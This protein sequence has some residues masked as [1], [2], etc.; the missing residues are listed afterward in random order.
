MLVTESHHSTDSAPTHSLV[1]FIIGITGHRDPLHLQT[2]N[3]T[4]LEIKQ[5]IK[6]CIVYWRKKLGDKTPIW[7]MSGMAEGCDLLALEALDELRESGITGDDNFAVFPCLP[8]PSAEYEKDFAESPEEYQ[9]GLAGFNRYLNE[10]RKNMIVVSEKFQVT[11]SNPLLVEGDDQQQ[12]NYQYLNVGLF[13]AKYS[14]VLIALWDGNESK[15]VGGTADIVRYKCG[16]G[17]DWCNDKIA[18][19]LRPH[20]EFDGQ[21]GGVVQHI[22]IVRRQSSSD[23]PLLS[24]LVQL[25]HKDYADT[26]FPLYVSHCLNRKINPIQTFLS[27]EFALLNQQ[28]IRFNTFAQSNHIDNSAAKITGIENGLKDTAGLFYQADASAVVH[29]KSYR[30][31]LGSFIRIA[32]YGLITY[33]VMSI[34]LNISLGIALNV[35]IL[36]CI[37]ALISLIRLEKKNQTKIKY[38]TFRC[39]AEALRIRAYLNLANVPPDVKPIIPRRYRQNWPIIN[40]ACRLAELTLWSQTIETNTSLVKSEWLQGQIDYLDS[41]LQMTGKSTIADFFYKRPKK[42]ATFLAKWSRRAFTL[43]IVVATVL[44]FIQIAHL[45]HPLC[46]SYSDHWQCNQ[47]AQLIQQ[48]KTDHWL[49]NYTLLSVQFALMVG[50]IMALWQELANYQYTYKGYENLR[51]LYVRALYL[52]DK[53]QNDLQTEMLAELAQEAMEEHA[54]WNHSEHQTDLIHR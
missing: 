30:N 29:Q 49:A 47:M 28:I 11:Q 13:I 6:N 54:S 16:E 19:G 40:Y 7:L 53:E 10:H 42:A 37:F 5:A 4:A 48:Y 51:M 26:P 20:S 25:E 23:E 50:T 45:I 43:A 24:K 38:Q 21:I 39:V 9:F 8:M 22:P 12:R 36:V 15:G 18:A 14:H 44:I 35:A 46:A 41:R 32:L 52:L 17:L 33:E 3:S 27:N 34:V 2:E 31:N 1:P